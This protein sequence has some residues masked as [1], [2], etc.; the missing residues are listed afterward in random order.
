MEAT[1]I[2]LED[3]QTHPNDGQRVAFSRPGEGEMMKTATFNKSALC[4]DFDDGTASPIQEYDEYLPFPGNARIEDL[5]LD[6]TLRTDAFVKLLAQSMVRTSCNA[7]Y[8]SFGEDNSERLLAILA[9][10]PDAVRAV[11]DLYAKI[12][13]EDGDD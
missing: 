3:P 9:Q 12:T 11:D 7:I 6:E 2:V 5:A 4:W 13:E 10:K 8:L 1:E